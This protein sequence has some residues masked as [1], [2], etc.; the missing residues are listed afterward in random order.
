MKSTGLL[1]L[2]LVFGFVMI[3]HGIQKAFEWTPAGTVASFEQ[4]GIPMAAAAAYFAMA[5]ELVGGTMIILGAGTRIAAAASVVS[6]SGALIF[7]HLAAGR[8]DSGSARPLSTRGEESTAACSTM[9]PIVWVGGIVSLSG[10]L[11]CLRIEAIAAVLR[12]RAAVH[13]PSGN[14]PPPCMRHRLTADECPHWDSNPEHKDFKSSVSANWTM[15]ARLVHT[16]HRTPLFH[17]SRVTHIRS[18]VP[19]S[20]H[21]LSPEAG[22]GWMTKCHPWETP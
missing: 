1:I 6:M 15:G 18:S 8:A 13:F 16:K 22:A 12:R 5:T 3:M 20:P 9:P 17:E 14:G 11:F 7:V 4:M 19:N 21:R 2:R 10:T